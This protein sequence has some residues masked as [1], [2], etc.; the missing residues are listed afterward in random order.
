QGVAAP[1][2]K[3]GACKGT[4]TEQFLQIDAVPFAACRVIALEIQRAIQ[5]AELEITRIILIFGFDAPGNRVRHGQLI[6]HICACRW[7]EAIEAR[8][9]SIELKWS[10][11]LNR[12]V[13]VAGLR[14]CQGER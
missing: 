12:Y 1:P 10:T 13:D 5:D 6:D 14:A 3:A 7:I 8:T 11:A 9:F 4:R 2:G